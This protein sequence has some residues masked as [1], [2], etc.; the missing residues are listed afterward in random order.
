MEWPTWF[1][2]A[3]VWTTI[4]KMEWPTWF[5]YAAVTTSIVTCAMRT[6]VPLRILSLVCN[7]CFVIYGFFGAVYPTLFLNLILL[8]LNGFRLREMLE[9]THKVQAA[10]SGDRSFD[11]LKPFMAKRRERAGDIL[12]RKGDTA[13]S[14]YYTVTGRYRLAESGI[15]IPPGQVVGELALL[16]PDKRRTQTLECIEDGEVMVASYEQVKE[17]YFQNPEFGFHFLE[18]TSAR[19]FQNIARLEDE[20]ERKNAA[21]A[22]MT[23]PA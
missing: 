2:Y 20:L 23:K 18:L 22:A 9:L 13:D 17:L 11:W 4:V 21:L 15:E 1:G 5:G 7:S 19:L 8:P 6:M 16:A 3:A 10:V 14:M 12:F